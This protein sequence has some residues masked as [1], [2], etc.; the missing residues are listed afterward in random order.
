MHYIDPHGIYYLG[1]KG[2]FSHEAA[3]KFLGS[4]KGKLND[5]A[6]IANVFDSIK[7]VNDV[8]VVPIENSIEGPVNETLDNL[9]IHNNI[10]I[11]AIIHLPIKL[12]LASSSAKKI[13]D[14]KRVYS[15]YYAYK[16]AQNKLLKIGIKDVIPVEST[17]KAAIMSS[18]DYSSAALCS[19]FA[20]KL[21]NLNILADNLQ[22]HINITK[23]AVISKKMNYRGKRTTILFTVPDRPGGLFKILEIFYRN[24]IN[25]TMIY[26]RPLK[27]IPWHYYFYVEY[28]GS[29]N[30]SLLNKIRQNTPILK[31]KGSYMVK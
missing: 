31:I 11:N 21:Y 27:S 3:I 8:G 26:S 18:K 23:F 24:N 7:S 13:S 9:Y 12:V 19:L 15:H 29:I 2:S 20:A 6:T 16:E 22:D 10:Y 17:S 5:V 25:L 14:I 1:P 30:F 28:E 4:I